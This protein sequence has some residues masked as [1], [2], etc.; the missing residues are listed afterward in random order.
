MI[1]HV[2][3]KA[4]TLFSALLIMVASASFSQIAHAQT[5]KQAAKQNVITIES[6]VTGSKEEPKMMTV[7]PWKKTATPDLEQRIESLI[8]QKVSPL[9]RDELL[10]E[11]RYG[12]SPQQAPAP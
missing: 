10:R 1:N 8:D 11:I 2:A 6:T 5:Q 9:E 3:F 7:V 12:Q 4:N